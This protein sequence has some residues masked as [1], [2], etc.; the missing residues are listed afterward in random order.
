[1]SQTSLLSYSDKTVDFNH[2]TSTE[3]FIAYNKRGVPFAGSVSAQIIPYSDLVFSPISQ[4]KCINCG[5]YGRVFGCGPKT[6]PYYVWQERLSKYNFFLIVIGKI[7]VKARV[8]DGK[9]NYGQKSDW[10]AHF[11]A[12]N[13]GVNILKK[14]ARERRIETLNYLSVFGK[15]RTFSEG[16]GCR[17][18]VLPETKISLYSGE[19]KPAKDI[20]IGDLLLGYDL[21]K[22][23]FISNKI[24]DIFERKSKYK[25]KITTKSGKILNV[26]PEHPVYTRQGW[27]K[28]IDIKEGDEVISLGNS[29][30]F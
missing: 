19:T 3:N 16:G 30:N 14:R 5:M 23:R 24:K 7:D 11:Y 17:L 27:K 9:D 18:A 26:T 21:L 29:T 28:A 20:T 1:M 6:A 13:E 12:G 15:V 8:Q 4:L 22:D 2:L 25:I 10:R